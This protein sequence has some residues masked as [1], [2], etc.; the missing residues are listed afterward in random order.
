MFFSKLWNGFVGLFKVK[1]VARKAP[2]AKTKAPVAASSKDD[3]KKV[4]FNKKLIKTL[5]SDHKE[6]LNGFT[7]MITSVEA[8]NF[9]AANSLLQ[10]FGKKIVE[11]LT[12]EDVE[13]YVYLEFMAKITSE[14][15][16]I[17]KGFRSEMAEIATV[18]T[19]FL[20][21][22]TNSPISSAN[23]NQFLL[24]ANSAATILVSRID[25]EESVLYPMY[26]RYK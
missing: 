26:G 15:K 14:D 9:S 1:E 7:T 23:K 17:M 16:E 4:D 11:H 13:L 2:T 19:G 21:L 12:L 8:D 20:N 10:E 3:S 5:M 25:R 22:Y 24:E 18:V 6:L